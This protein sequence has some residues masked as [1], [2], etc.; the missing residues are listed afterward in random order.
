MNRRGLKKL[1][2]AL[3][4]SAGLPL[5]LVM[6][7]SAPP[8][9]T[10]P[11]RAE[12]GPARTVMVK[13]S[14][15]LQRAL[16]AARPGDEL[17][18]EAGATYVGNF[19]LPAR[20]GADSFVTVRSS[21]SAE[22]AEG[23]RVTPADA[24][25]MARLASAG[26]GPALKAT[27]GSNYFRF[28]GL[29]FTQGAAVGEYSYSIV[30][31]GDGAADGAQT[32]LASVPH[33]L[34]FDRCIVRTRDERTAAQRGITLNS[35]HTAVKNS[36]V[37]GIKWAGVETQAVGGWNGPGP[38][39]IEN[40]Y[41]EAAGINVMFG[42]AVPAINGL[43]PSDIVVRGNH[44][45]KPLSWKQ[46]DPAYGGR[47]WT[48]KNLL[49]LK[50]A[51]R[52]VIE[53]NVMEHSWAHAQIGW[54][55]IFNTANDSG[56]WSRIEDVELRNNLIRGAGNGI[57]LRARDES[58]GVK[59]ARVRVANNLLL[60]LGP[61]W[62]GYGI[63]FQILRGPAD[64]TIEHNT[65]EPPHAMLLLD[66]EAGEHC[67]NLRFTNNLLRHGA[68]GV[69]G[70]GGTIGTAAFEQYCRRWSF[71][72]NVIAGDDGKRY[73]ASNF[74]L[75]AFDAKFFADPTRGNYRVNHPRV[76]GRATD[77]KDPGCDFDELEAA[78]AWY[79]RPQAAGK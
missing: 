4:V 59:M 53:G 32:T 22:L 37:A 2:A 28:V 69:F 26:V 21:R 17:V 60:D 79:L 49:E 9:T 23:R 39:T 65:A 30:E 62:G 74:F 63:A 27:P 20:S 68:Y 75:A 1:V 11:R 24:P 41:L 38:F 19:V 70:N 33:H 61:R 36:Y 42:G 46:G 44:L 55:V 14:D 18:L 56:V 78:L 72:G 54:A 76:K 10:R 6:C 35:A 50:S 29:E 3:L 34:E 16:D 47:A 31:L 52:V 64:V 73:P 15:N 57:N 25:R 12:S 67:A 8:Q 66:G 43:I 77:G 5:A 40:N 48:V 51:R 45:Y 7:A 71:A 58:S 13:A